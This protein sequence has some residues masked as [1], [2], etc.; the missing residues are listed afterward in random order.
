MLIIL[1]PSKTMDETSQ[2]PSGLTPSMPALLSESKQLIHVLKSKSE[3]E[4]AALMGVSDALAS[5]N[6]RRF[7]AWHTPFTPQNARP[8]LFTF[9]GDVYSGLDA[10]TLSAPDVAYAQSHLRILS[11]LYGLLRPLDLMQPY[12]LEMGTTLITPRGKNLYQFWGEKIAHT[13]T[14]DARESGDD[15]LINLASQ[16]Y[17]AAID[18]KILSLREITVQF[19]QRRGNQLKIIGLM[20]KRARGMMARFLIRE[21]VTSLAQL[22]EFCDGG[23]RFEKELSHENT[24]VFVA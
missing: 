15:L 5:I 12:R 24:L 10:P 14:A 21:R 16:E 23:Y 2:L 1:S 17:S 9:T 3:K 18:R 22:C 11:G 19:K 8:A 13:L 6:Y 20:A 4:I 7:E